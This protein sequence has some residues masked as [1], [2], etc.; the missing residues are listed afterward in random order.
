MYKISRR[1]RL[2]AMI[3]LAIV[4][5]LVVPALAQSL[6]PLPSTSPD[7]MLAV[8]NAARASEGL[9]PLTLDARL[10][11]AACR[12]ARDLAGRALHD[13]EALSHQ[14][15]DGSTLATRLQDAGY[16]Y[17]AAAENLAAGAR[18]PQET[19][20]LWL[21]SDGHRRNLLTAAFREAGAAY[22]GPRLSPGGN[23]QGP[24][25]VWVLVLAT[26][27]GPQTETPEAK[28]PKDCAG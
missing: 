9:A 8:V 11:A 27:A 25:D 13:V 19:T 28:N 21:A 20:R 2:A 12:Q 4:A 5:M 1:P 16:G 23:R 18:D 14:G 17:R 24:L 7:A 26:P 22:L 3:V 6:N 10:N 15:S